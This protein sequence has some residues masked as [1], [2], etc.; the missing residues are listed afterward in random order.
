MNLTEL[1]MDILKSKNWG[2]FYKA[3]PLQT[4]AMMD[5]ESPLLRVN[6]VDDEE[7]KSAII[8]AIERYTNCQKNAQ[9]DQAS[10]Q[11]EN[12]TTG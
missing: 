6:V 12:S 2:I 11:S 10:N 9:I 8:E 5:N 7:I 3:K 4:L 1:L